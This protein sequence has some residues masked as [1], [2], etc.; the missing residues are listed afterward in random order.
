[1]NFS[2]KSIVDEDLS[3]ATRRTKGVEALW[4]VLNDGG[5]LE[6]EVWT[7]SR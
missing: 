7:G 2:M 5:S 6:T 4:I 3:V 1:M